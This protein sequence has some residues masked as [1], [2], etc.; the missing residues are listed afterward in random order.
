M[1]SEAKFA[2]K[3]SPKR[4]VFLEVSSISFPSSSVAFSASFSLSLL[5]LMSLFKSFICPASSLASEEFFPCSKITF[6]YSVSKSFSSFSCFE[7]SFVSLLSGVFVSSI[8]DLYF[9]ISLS[10]LESSDSALLSEILQL[11]VRLSFSPYFS[12]DSSKALFKVEIFSFCLS[13]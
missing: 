6:L 2:F 10:I 3:T 13:I 12:L 9:S 7:I 5:S 1:K 8:P 4:L 11:F